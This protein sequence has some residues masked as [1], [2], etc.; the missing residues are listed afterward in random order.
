MMYRVCVY[1]VAL[2]PVEY[3]IACVKIYDGVVLR[4]KLPKSTFEITK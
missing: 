2:Q 3:G 4:D 1:I